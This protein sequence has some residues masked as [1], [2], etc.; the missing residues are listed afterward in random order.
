M[1]IHKLIN[2]IFWLI[3]D[4]RGVDRVPR[5]IP[6]VEIFLKIHLQNKK[7]DYNAYIVK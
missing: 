7:F 2:N 6:A 5:K 3:C 4:C 1:S